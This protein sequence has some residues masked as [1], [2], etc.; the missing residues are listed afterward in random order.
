MS[1]KRSRGNNSLAPAIHKHPKSQTEDYVDADV[2]QAKISGDFC[3][4]ELCL[5]AL[6]SGGKVPTW[7]VVSSAMEKMS[8]T[9]FAFEDLAMLVGIWPAA[10]DCSW[11]LV[12]SDPNKAKTPQLCVKAALSQPTGAF[13]GGT[14]SQNRMQHFNSLL[15]Q[16]IQTNKATG[17]KVN[18]AV[19]PARPSDF[20]GIGEGVKTKSP[21]RKSSLCQFSSAERQDLQS[22]NLAGP[23]AVERPTNGASS[24]VGGIAQLRLEAIERERASKL[25]EEQI[26]RD[27][28]KA[29]NTALLK[30][31]LPLCDSLRS[32]ALSRNKRSTFVS[33]ELIRDLVLSLRVSEEELKIR[34][35]K[36][37]AELPEF[38][39]LLPAD[40]RVPV[41]TVKINLL[42]EYAEVRRK[43]L[44]LHNG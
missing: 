22:R 4:L 9:A 10:F 23:A 5:N 24:S 13:V 44:M 42:V 41:D 31:L 32:L 28:Q 18:L 16:W 11:R 21:K 35:A 12:S 38:L 30:A 20:D 29:A 36:A 3:K 39:T 43:C 33:T 25:R 7:Q 40:D 14:P 17:F 8:T 2:L 1:V 6:R 27:R 26:H 34:L 15:T 19:I 37:A